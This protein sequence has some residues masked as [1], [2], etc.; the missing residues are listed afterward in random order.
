VSVSTAQ[1]AS[2]TWLYLKLYPGRLDLLD[3]VATDVVG[4]FVTQHRVEWSRWF[5]LRYHDASGPHV[6]LRMSLEPDAADAIAL[7]ASDLAARFGDLRALRAADLNVPGMLAPPGGVAA[8]FDSDVV[9]DLY[10]PEWTK[11]GGP[12]YLPV[13]EHMFEH[14]SV[15]ALD[16][17]DVTRRGWQ[18][19]LAVAV[20]IID[21]SLDRVG[22]LGDDRARFLDEH[23]RWW[24]GGASL[25]DPRRRAL[26]GVVEAIAGQVRTR[27]GEHAKRGDCTD[28]V[29]DFTRALATTLTI[30]NPEQKPAYLLFHHL[31]LMLNRVGVSPHEEALVSLL[32][33]RDPQFAST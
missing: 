8:T 18:D 22:L 29:G 9:V 33:A 13:A 19:R 24:S 27:R 15:A 7:E 25:T 5:F 21:D 26:D 23:F 2:R 4:P 16:L 6:R 3:A 10:E 30:S 12:A 32:V 1:S 31:H 28:P 11:W 20:A 17:I 14:S